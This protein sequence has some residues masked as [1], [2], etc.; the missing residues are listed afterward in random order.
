MKRI[1]VGISGATACCGLQLSTWRHCRRHRFPVAQANGLCRAMQL[2]QNTLERYA[3][4]EH[5][6][7]CFSECEP[8]GTEISLPTMPS[9]FRG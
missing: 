9:Y 1:I 3:P 4:A 8:K 2:R 7:K 5:V 6:T